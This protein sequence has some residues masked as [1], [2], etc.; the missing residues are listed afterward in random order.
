MPTIL[1]TSV[2]SLVGHNVLTALRPVRDELFVI[3]LETS[4]DAANNF[5]C[6]AA[7][8]VPPTSDEAQFEQRLGEI[9]VTA[10]VDLVF[11]GTDTDLP[12]LA[13]ISV[14]ETLSESVFLVPPPEIVEICNDK[15][16]TYRFAREHGLPFATTAAMPSELEGMLARHG[17]PFICKARRGSATKG[18]FLV[19][20]LQEAEAAL[21]DDRF[22]LQPYLGDLGEVAEIQSPH[23]QG[24]PLSVTF[25]AVQY[26]TQFLIGRNGSILGYFATEAVMVGGRSISC[27][28]IVDSRLDAVARHY[29]ERLA[30]MG[31]RGPLN[32]QSK[33]LP[34][35]QYVPFELNARFTG[36]TDARALMGYN[37]VLL[38]IEHF[39]D[40]E[41]DI[42]AQNPV[43]Q[44]RF[45]TRIMTSYATDRQD[46]EALREQGQWT[47]ADRNPGDNPCS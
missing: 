8:L 40:I 34:D 9:V 27:T 37:E 2:G 23:P 45:I 7:Y 12:L 5:R 3:G 46:V 38:A 14:G 22:I 10:N 19:R 32:I 31:Y 1:I 24:S 18:V 47:R 17:Y 4:P 13:K 25:R 15:Y 33:R 26:S 41:L 21:D 35:G 20:G 39:L 44:Q 43:L 29:G 11:S 28:P 16:E 36:Q 6:D 42:E 30:R